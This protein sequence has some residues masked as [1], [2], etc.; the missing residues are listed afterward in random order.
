MAEL[1]SHANLLQQENDR[2]RAHLEGEHIEKAR[3]SSHPAPPGK[4]NKGKEP[5]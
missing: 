5:I 3:E 1:Q 2:L 4:Q